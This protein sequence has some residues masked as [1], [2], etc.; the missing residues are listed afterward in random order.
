[1]LWS[2][3]GQCHQGLPT[4]RCTSCG[5]SVRK[6][7]TDTVCALRQCP[8]ALLPTSTAAQALSKATPRAPH[9]PR[10]SSLPHCAAQGASPARSHSLGEALPPD[11]GGGAVGAKD[12]FFCFQPSLE[13]VPILM[14]L[15]A[16]PKIVTTGYFTT[17][18]M[19]W[20]MPAEPVLHSTRQE[21][22]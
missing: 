19:A 4:Q 8:P 3:F 2:G 21:R 15:C 16:L 13:V 12:T 17:S 11:L 5:D 6:L 9:F 14:F 20:P 18:H 1:M 7:C 22:A 10:P